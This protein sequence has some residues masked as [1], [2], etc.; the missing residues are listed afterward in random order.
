MKR[1]IVPLVVAQRVRA[2]LAVRFAVRRHTV[3][4]LAALPGFMLYCPSMIGRRNLLRAARSGV[5]M[6]RQ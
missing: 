6:K 3:I 4:H 2:V 5:Q 1:D